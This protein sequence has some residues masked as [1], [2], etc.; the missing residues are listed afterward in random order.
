VKKTKI[1]LLL[2]VLIS[3][4]IAAQIGADAASDDTGRKSAKGQI[5]GRLLEY[6]TSEPIAGR[7]VRLFSPKC[8]GTPAGWDDVD[9]LKIEVT[10]SKDGTF[11]FEKLNPGRYIFM[12]RIKL[13]SNP[14]PAYANIR[15]ENAKIIEVKLVEDQKVDLGKVWTQIP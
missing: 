7:Q 11:K 5:Q 9:D 1:T 8:A 13:L 12:L 10:T 6:E 15:Y 3:I 14:E 4:F 2:L